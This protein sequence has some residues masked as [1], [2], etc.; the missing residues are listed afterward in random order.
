MANLHEDVLAWEQRILDWERVA[1]KQFDRE[2]MTA[3]LIRRFPEPLR[4]HIQLRASDFKTDH[5]RL[6]DEIVAFSTTTAIDLHDRG[7]R[8]M[9][10]G[11]LTALTRSA[12]SIASS[13]G[14]SASV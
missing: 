6:K 11:A 5:A 8:P 12:S 7:V 13:A 4:Q 14:V 2:L 3:V 10:L 9:D 1:Q